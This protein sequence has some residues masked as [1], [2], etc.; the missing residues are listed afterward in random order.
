MNDRRRPP[1]ATAQDHE[2]GTA[3]HPA[4][5][6]DDTA[7]ASSGVPRSHVQLRLEGVYGS[8]TP[9]GQKL[10]DFILQH[11]EQLLHMTI[12]ELAQAA[13]VS[14]A[15]VTRLCQAV[16]Y[17]GFSE[18]RVLF[19]RDQAV[20]HQRAV[21]QLKS[22]DA[23]EEIRD[24]VIAGTVAGLNDT[25]TTLDLRALQRAANAI[26][27]ARRVDVYG[28]GGSAAVA[29]DI[30][31]K[32]LRLGIPITAHS[33][34]DIMAISSSTLSADDVAIGVSHTGRTEPVVAAVRRARLGGAGTIG[35]THA[36]QSPLA[37]HCDAVL[38]YAAKRTAFSADSLT[39][40]IAQL[41][42]A[43]ILYA[44]IASSTYEQSALLVDQANVLADSRRIGA[45][46]RPE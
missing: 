34:V 6:P 9:A 39:G 10:C 5:A 38:A 19:A 30:R 32:L 33:D 35:L 42:I 43:D 36:P 7:N 15:T 45:R 16:G 17:L 46:R 23:S 12:T 14:D 26:A 40:R 4:P 21:G 3:D 31:H 8:L 29:L 44:T 25:C 24:K 18:F 11:P 27:K 37:E 20:A 13:G 22:T 41:V 2:N 28:V 1:R